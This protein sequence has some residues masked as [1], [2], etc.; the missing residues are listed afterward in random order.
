MWGGGSYQEETVFSWKMVSSLTYRPVNVLSIVAGYKIYDFN[1]EE[2]SGEEAFELDA[3][4]H[5]PT[6]TMMVH[7]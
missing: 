5:G 4:F 2:G 6:L 7:F 3:L 1:Y